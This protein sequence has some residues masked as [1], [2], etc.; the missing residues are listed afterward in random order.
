MRHFFSSLLTN[1]L[2]KPGP[3]TRAICYLFVV[4]LVS[5]TLYQDVSENFF[6]NIK[7]PINQY[8]V[9][10]AWGW[11]LFPLSALLSLSTI[12]RHRTLI[13]G[14][15]VKSWLR[16]ALCTAVWYCFA[17]SL[18]P[19]VEES[20]G[21]CEVSELRT[22]RSCIRAGYIWRGFDISG[23]CFLLTWN[24]LVIIEE[25]LAL[26]KKNNKKKKR[27]KKKRKKKE[28]KEKRREPSL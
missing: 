6:S 24:N 14:N 4:G 5:N 7:N 22:K 11:T 23:H 1:Y 2:Y 10:Y 15:S 19:Y 26:K 28:K 20:T 21:V 9:K 13:N 27:K 8:F 25:T 12:S 16:L 17:Q 3:G 18:F